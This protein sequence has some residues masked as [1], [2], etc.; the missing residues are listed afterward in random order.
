MEGTETH[1]LDQSVQKKE[2]GRLVRNAQR[3]EVFEKGLRRTVGAATA[4]GCLG[5]EW[6]EWTAAP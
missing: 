5:S 3:S 2:E 1:G 6:E 4:V